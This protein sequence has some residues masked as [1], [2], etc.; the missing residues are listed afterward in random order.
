MPT[1]NNNATRYQS[2][3]PRGW[4]IISTVNGKLIEAGFTSFSEANKRI[5]ALRTPQLREELRKLS[6]GNDRVV[7]I[8][9]SSLRAVSN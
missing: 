5:R 3:D 2:T 6:G 4:R 1:R 7:D 8:A 9:V